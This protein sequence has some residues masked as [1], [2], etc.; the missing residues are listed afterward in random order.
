MAVSIEFTEEMKGFVTFGEMDFQRGREQGEKN[1]STLMF[2]LRIMLEDVTR[3]IA[4]PEH[5][6]R[7]DGYIRCPQLGARDC[8][9]ENG[10]FNLFVPGSDANRKLMLY[11][12]FSN[13]EKGQP[14]TLSGFKDIADDSNP[15]IDEIWKD[16]STL[17]TRLLRGHVSAGEEKAGAEVLASGIINILKLDFVEQ[18]TTFKTSGGT[19]EERIRAQIGFGR[20]FLGSL[21]DVYG[22]KFK[23]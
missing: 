17:F 20:L 9:V 14:F 18:L 22:S 10:I 15:D 4:D 13:D 8:T 11:R 7:A 6:G 1:N 2:H 5:A 21:W 16:T 23:L 3:F 19:H 12:L